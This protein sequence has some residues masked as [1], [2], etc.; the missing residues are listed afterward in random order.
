M[1]KK[2]L[3]AGSFDPIT[4][5]HLDI[6]KRTSKMY[7]EVVVGVITNPNK[8]ALFDVKERTDMIAC[9]TRNLDNIKIVSFSGLLAKYVNDNHFDVVIRGL[10]VTTDFEY[11]IQMAQMNS[12]L[13]NK[14]IETVF[15]MT[16]PKYSF[17]SSSMIK[18][19]VM[20]GGEVKGLVPDEICE[21]TKSKFNIK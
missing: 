9:T 8:N 3:Y 5:G 21:L 4:C 16:Q 10:R 6:I 19:V 11:E 18:E 13:Y 7:D 1:K 14:D 17:I 20:L 15:L 12:R 2:A